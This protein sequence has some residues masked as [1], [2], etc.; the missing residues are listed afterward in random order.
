MIAWLYR[1]LSMSRGLGVWI[2]ALFAWFV[3]TGYFVFYPGRVRTSLALYAAAF[4]ERGWWSRLALTWRQF[5][6]FSSLFAER[7]RLG[8]GGAFE[9]ERIGFEH[10]ERLAHSGS[11][12]ILLMSHMGAWEAA[13]RIFKRRKIPLM[14]F[15]GQRQREQVEKMQKDDL[16][17]GGVSLIVASE[18]GGGSLDSLEGLSFLRK[19][20]L[21]SFAGDRLWAEGQRSVEVD[22]L[23]HKALVP[24]GPHLF[25]L[26]SG[27]EICVF[28]VL[29]SGRRKYRLEAMEPF[30]V[31]AATRAD[32]WPA[33]E[34]SAQAYARNLEDV[35]RRYPSQWYHFEEFIPSSRG[36]LVL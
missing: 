28:F 20:G 18:Q 2:V 12:G 25:A 17:E 36:T 13:A 4:P 21:I 35:L 26:A 5:H 32:R 33:I 8:R 11:G 30:R 23:G 10:V 27:A 34:R 24:A 29:R 1:L 15:M 16:R 22:F 3:S 19:G 9:T 14:L 7:L 31:E 6:N